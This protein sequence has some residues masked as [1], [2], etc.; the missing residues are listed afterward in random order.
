MA[1]S[2]MRNSLAMAQ[3]ADALDRGLRV[4][5]RCLDLGRLE[6]LITAHD[7]AASFANVAQE[8]QYALEPLDLAALGCDEITVKQAK[9][10]LEQLQKVQAP[11]P[12]EQQRKLIQ[13]RKLSEAMRVQKSTIS[14]S[15]DPDSPAHH[16]RDTVHG[17]L[18][19]CA[20][21]EIAGQVAPLLYR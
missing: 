4:T 2:V 11:F 19:G 20:F 5:Q 14:A 8:L 13:L 7:V 18:D 17:V 21:T 1:V 3:V 9:I 10:T 15:A 12:E 16:L 6:A